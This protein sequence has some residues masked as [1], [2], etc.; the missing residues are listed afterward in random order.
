MQ[1]YPELDLMFNPG[2]ADQ[3][4]V[5]NELNIRSNCRVGYAHRLMLLNP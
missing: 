1:E 5:K 3:H 4:I 2:N